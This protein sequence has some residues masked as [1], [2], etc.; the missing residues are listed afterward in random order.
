M[1]GNGKNRKLSLQSLTC[2]LSAETMT[3]TR[4][5]TSFL[6]P[7]FLLALN[8][9][10]KFPGISAN[11]L[12]LD[13]PFSVYNAQLDIG[14][15]ISFLNTGN[16]PPLFELLLHYWIGWTGIGLIAVRFLPYVFSCLSAVGVFFLGKK[17][18]SA[19]TGLGGALLFTC[20]SFNMYFAHEAR[21]YSLFTLL[22][23]ASLYYYCCLLKD[24][25]RKGFI[26]LLLSNVLLLFSHYFGIW[27]V[28][29]ELLLTF[30]LFRENK[31]AFRKV[32]IVFGGTLIV[33]FPLLV[34]FLSRVKDT[35][36]RGTWMKAP[37]LDG[38]YENLRKF[39][40]EPVPAVIFLVLIGAGIWKLW[41]LGRF[42]GNPYLKMLFLFFG[43]TYT[44]LFLIS[45]IVPLFLDR[46]LIFLSIPFYL[47]IIESV[48]ALGNG[49]VM[50]R[51]LIFLPILLMAITLNCYPESGRKP[52]EMAKFVLQYK[53]TETPV[54]ISPPWLDKGLLYYC[55]RELFLHPEAFAA[56]MNKKGWFPVYSITEA[57]EKTPE[58]ISR[59]VYVSIGDETGEQWM[60][61]FDRNDW[62]YML[63]ERVFFG[64]GLCVNVF[65][66]LPE[67]KAH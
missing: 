3:K 57:A 47:I 10:L 31:G 53:N 38:F 5:F 66:H 54:F 23:C 59:I 42:K 56:G 36:H 64:K 37:P 41:K 46:Y 40:N 48:M 62:T 7:F 32:I 20:S 1:S 14:S 50:K 29:G 34:I 22:S 21:V 58:K 55:D 18:S 16:N 63:T 27:V 26:G 6:I 2:G 35:L 51:I 12:S 52:E 9:V 8:L 30:L 45:F 17:I 60:K 39:S 33:F 4:R 44:G 25:S 49:N 43:I 13:E 24:K 28:G 11:G 65:E 61:V 19:E 15:L 67:H